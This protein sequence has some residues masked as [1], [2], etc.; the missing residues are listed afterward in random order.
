MN[1]SD[2]DTFKSSKSEQI[3]GRYDEL[4]LQGAF[5]L[6]RSIEGIYH[7]PTP[8]EDPMHTWACTY[9][10]THKGNLRESLMTS[11]GDGSINDDDDG[12]EAVEPGKLAM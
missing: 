7:Q 8:G 12:E 4:K 5:C 9:P 10:G 6:T 11:L 1:T 3:I 2:P